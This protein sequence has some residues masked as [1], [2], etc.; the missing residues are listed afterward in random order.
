MDILKLHVEVHG[1]K[2]DGEGPADII[3]QAYQDWLAR[4]GQA[5]VA[6]AAPPADAWAKQHNATNPPPGA[7]QE[8]YSRVYSEKD[9]VI[10][11][12]VL[13]KSADAEGDALVLLVHGYQRLR[14]SEYPITAVRLA[15]VAKVSGV[16][17]DRLDRALASKSDLI[18]KA[19]L[20]RGTKYSLNNRGEQHAIETMKTLF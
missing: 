9:G 12:H 5:P 19:G 8:L 2:F 10:S 4:V 15:Q 11:L 16:N 3:K 20:R 1:N 18:M 6:P 7:M 17:I 13:P 14:P